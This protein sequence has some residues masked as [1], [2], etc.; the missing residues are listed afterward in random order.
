MLRAAERLFLALFAALIGVALFELTRRAFGIER[1]QADLSSFAALFTEPGIWRAAMLG[2]WTG[3]ASTMLTVL[4]TMLAFAGLFLNRHGRLLESVSRPILAMPHAAFAFGLFLFLTPGGWFFRFVHEVTGLFP[5]PPAFATVNDEMG[6]ALIVALMLKEVPFL[7]L[8]AMPTLTRLMAEGHWRAALALGHA[9]AYAFLHVI[10][11]RLYADLRL[12]V[13]AVLVYGAS[14]VDMAQILGPTT[15]PT[16]AVLLARLISAGGA[17]GFAQGEAGS[18]ALILLCLAAAGAW[19]AL[20]RCGALLLA[21]IRRAGWRGGALEGP[22]HLTAIAVAGLL[23]MSAAFAIA[24]LIVSSLSASWPWPALWPA[25]IDE[26]GWMKADLFGPILAT[27]CCWRLSR[28][29]SA[30]CWY[31]CCWSPAETG[32]RAAGARLS[33]S[34]R[35]CCRRSAWWP[36]SAWLWSRSALTTA[37]PLFA[38]RICF[39]SFLTSTC[40]SAGHG[41]RSTRASHRLQRRWGGRRFRP[42][43]MCAC[44]Y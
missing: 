25:R 37:L 21:S 9:P 35:F 33:F 42:S 8:V 26:Q 39:T 12:P 36:G 7:V 43:C 34:R 40:P 20:E 6:V 10:W 24:T 14:V 44:R 41:S 1:G 16:F 29:A 23:A 22:A 30:R 17:D 5:E 38:W 31:C 11:P 19:L 15:P 18:V 2:L 4:L 27:R 28:P 3:L 32:G 13:F